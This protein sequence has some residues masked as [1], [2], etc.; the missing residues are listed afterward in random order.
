MEDVETLFEGTSG[1]GKIIPIWFSKVVFKIK[2]KIIYF[3]TN[4][5]FT[6]MNYEIR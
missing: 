3:A 4:D 1:W 5:N 6:N 2:S